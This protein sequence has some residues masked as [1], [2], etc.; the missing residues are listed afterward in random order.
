MILDLKEVITKCSNSTRYLTCEYLIPPAV[1][2]PKYFLF[3][4]TF[5]YASK[6]VYFVD[7]STDKCVLGYIERHNLDAILDSWT[8]YQISSDTKFRHR[9]RA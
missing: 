7:L 8:I 4:P 9:F 1:I 2:A 3:R 6:I 5:G